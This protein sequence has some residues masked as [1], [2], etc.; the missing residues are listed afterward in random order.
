MNILLFLLFLAGSSYS[1]GQIITNS[2]GDITLFDMVNNIQ[3]LNTL[4]VVVQQ[5]QPQ[6]SMQYKVALG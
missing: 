4:G 3:R 6:Y 2:N 5:Q 1:F